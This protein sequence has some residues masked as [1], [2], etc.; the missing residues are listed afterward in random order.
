MLIFQWVVKWKINVNPAPSK[1]AVQIL[2]SR[3]SNQIFHLLIY[4]NGSEVKTVNE[5]KHLG[6]ILDAKLSFASHIFYRF[7]QIFKMYIRPHLDFC[8]VI[9]HVPSITNPFDVS[10]NLK[11]LM[12]TLERIQYHTALAI[13]GTWIGTN[14]NK[15]Y[16]KLD[17]GSL[18][19]L[20]TFHPSV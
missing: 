1:Q 8:D 5:H 20:D 3:K 12:N 4:V 6:L 16:D 17:W 18:I 10:I 14:L 7:D 11:N 2:F 15:I 9:Y 19:G 13:T